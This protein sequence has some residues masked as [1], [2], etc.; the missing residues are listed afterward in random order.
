MVML[1]VLQPDRLGHRKVLH[2]VEQVRRR[3]VAFEV[4]DRRTDARDTLLVVDDHPGL[5][6]IAAG[7]AVPRA[8]VP[9]VGLRR[10]RSRGVSA[11]KTASGATA[12][13]RIAMG[14]LS[15][16]AFYMM[17]VTAALGRGGVRVDRKGEF[18]ME[19]FFPPI[20]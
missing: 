10:R 20:V 12:S 9:A 16:L 6:R 8:A 11:V 19:N 7:P 1:P 3:H 14:V 18:G 15:S 4:H 2:H 17:T 5:G 13:G